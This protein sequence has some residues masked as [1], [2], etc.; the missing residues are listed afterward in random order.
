[1][2][3]IIRRLSLKGFRSINATRV[4]FDNPTFLVGRN[5]AGKSNL[6]DALAFLSEAMSFNLQAPIAKR[7]QDGGEV[8]HIPN[9]FHGMPRFGISVTFGRLEGAFDSAH[10]SFEV[11]SRS[12]VVF[13]VV[14]EQCRITTENQDFWFDRSENRFSS[15]PNLGGLKPDLDPSGLGLPAISGYIPFTA[16]ARILKGIEAFPSGLNV[17][18]IAAA[19]LRIRESSSET[20]ARI[21]EILASVL[22]YKVHVRPV[23]R[24]GKISLVF[25][26]EWNGDKSSLGVGGVSDGTL[27]MLGLLTAAFWQPTPSLIA[28]EEPE[29][30]LHPGA[31]GLVLD[32][33]QF[34]SDKTQ[35]VVATHSPELLEGK[36]IGDRHLRVAVWEDGSTRICPIAEG[37]RKALAEHLAGAG[38]LLR[39]DVLDAPPLCEG[40]EEV[41]LFEALA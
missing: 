7:R 22:P 26:H 40:P 11:E 30:G 8:D 36:W 4:E 20:A 12:L 10:Y 27:Q 19:L 24:D 38:E 39:S 18:L 13:K 25:E 33:L 29:T 14:R 9:R 1:M 17:D 15:S 23:E 37:A 41:E 2:D 31:L 35:V 28:I 16:V 3:P 6:L 5:G 34:A 32:L 21:D